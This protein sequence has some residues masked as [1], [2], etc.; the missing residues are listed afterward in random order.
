MTAE[1]F[2]TLMRDAFDVLHGEREV[3]AC[4]VHFDDQFET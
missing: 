3:A 2:H 1:W 4:T